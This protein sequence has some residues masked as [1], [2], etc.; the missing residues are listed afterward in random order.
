MS[1]HCKDQDQYVDEAMYVIFGV[2]LCYNGFGQ[3]RLLARIWDEQFSQVY[4]TY[5]QSGGKGPSFQSGEGPA[6]TCCVEVCRRRMLHQ[7]RLFPL[8]L[9]FH[10]SFHLGDPYALPPA[11]S[12][13]GL[14]PGHTVHF[15]PLRPDLGIAP[16][17][18]GRRRLHTLDVSPGD[19]LYHVGKQDL[20][21]W[22]AQNLEGWAALAWS[23]LQKA[24]AG[25]TSWIE[26]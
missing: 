1:E 25:R 24:V 10:L 7:H 8:R 5:Q 22:A 16:A 2:S 20:E 14:D 18:L 26:E 15:R 17:C 13:H 11:A 19:S 21:D 12:L 4:T 9:S 6:E 23:Q 3:L